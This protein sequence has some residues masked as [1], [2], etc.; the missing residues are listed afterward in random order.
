[1][2]FPLLTPVASRGPCPGGPHRLRSRCSD[3]LAV[4][5][6][7]VGFTGHQV[8]PFGFAA[9]LMVLAFPPTLHSDEPE[10]ELPPARVIEVDQ[11]VR[12]RIDQLEQLFRLQ[13]S[14]GSSQAAT[15]AEPEEARAA[16]D[17]IVELLDMVQQ[18]GTRLPGRP[19]VP[20]L[21]AVSMGAGRFISLAEYCQRQL[22]R[23]PPAVRAH[24]RGQV[25]AIAA[26]WYARGIAAR[27]EPLLR[28]LVDRMFLSEWGD[29]SLLALGEMNLER[30]DYQQARIDW[31]RILAARPLP[32]ESTPLSQVPTGLLAYPDTDLGQ[33]MVWARL[34]LV[35]IRARQFTRARIEI[36]RL[37]VAYPTASGKLGGEE[38]IYAD[39]LAQLLEAARLEP[40]RNV[41]GLGGSSSPGQTAGAPALR[42]TGIMSLVRETVTPLPVVVGHALCYGDWATPEVG[43]ISESGARINT[44]PLGR[45]HPV[46]GPS[47]TRFTFPWRSDRRQEGKTPPQEGPTVYLASDA[48]RSVWATQ[49]VSQQAAA[50]RQAAGAENFPMV[51]LDLRRDGAV[52]FRQRPADAQWA[53][54]GPPRVSRSVEEGRRVLVAMTERSVA[55]RFYVACYQADSGRLLWRRPLGELPVARPGE[56]DMA[57]RLR[58][59]P[60]VLTL[61]GSVVYCNTNRGVVAALRVRDGRLQWLVTY[62]REVVPRAEMPSGNSARTKARWPNACLF[63]QGLLLLA[64]TDSRELLALDAASGTRVWS[65]RVPLPAVR[66]LG[67][68][69]G[70]LILIGE[71]LWAIDIISGEL[72]DG[73]GV[74]TAGWGLHEDKAGI[75]VIA[76]QTIY[77]PRAG[78]IWSLDGATGWPT[79]MVLET[80]NESAP[81][82]PSAHLPER[83]RLLIAGNR[84]IAIGP[85][86]IAVYQRASAESNGEPVVR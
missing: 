22:A 44:L 65:R 48:D 18:A 82:G 79:A 68:I 58:E 80:A 59:A 64:P 61:D 56:P 33:A 6:F 47:A 78:K 7:L 54:S 25:E 16:L 53:F 17:Q 39:R 63:Y 70:N 40:P 30:A 9:F 76:G 28:Q 26:A 72:V 23:L 49:L 43:K 5:F 81:Q 57:T 77:W 19:D 35:S 14:G 45:R 38:G 41:S 12:R 69:G 1:M 66:I 85:D 74:K 8:L 51:G 46:L 62:P 4:P 84:L 71:Q 52:F 3:N 11:T 83:A 36:D 32:L 34:A 24:Y 67:V 73:W 13:E 31:S 10:W 15:R 2:V 86:A 21:G 27:D 55:D 50:N 29:N 75:G 42:L 20:P 37:R 60:V